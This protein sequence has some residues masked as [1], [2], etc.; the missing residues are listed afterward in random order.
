M[1][2]MIKMGLL[3]A[4][5]GSAA[6]VRAQGPVFAGTG[7]VFEAG[8]GYTYMQSDVPS[9][10]KVPMTG[11]LLSVSE[12]LN[13]HF[14]VKVQAG[15]SRSFDAFQTGHSA[16]VLTYMAGPTLYAVRRSKFDIHAQLLVGGARETGVNFENG[17][18][19][20]R[21]YVNHAAWAGGAGVQFRVRRGVTLRP[22]VE[23]LSTSFFNSSVAI[24]RHTNLRAS[25]SMIYTFGAGRE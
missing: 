17:G 3:V 5:L 19:L 4:A 25:L 21:G 1:R 10:G 7:R 12:D 6:Q 20:V 22:E 2:I 11:V 15:Y 8:I 9:L 13:P 18:T 16:D 14:G 23:Y 24:Q